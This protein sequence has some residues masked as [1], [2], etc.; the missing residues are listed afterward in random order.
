MSGSMIIKLVSRKLCLSKG[1]LIS[2]DR[3]GVLNV[4][5]TPQFGVII[6]ITQKS[7]VIRHCINW[8]T[9]DIQY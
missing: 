5:V 6:A 2:I 7:L 4:L 3:Q 1:K 9:I 8:N